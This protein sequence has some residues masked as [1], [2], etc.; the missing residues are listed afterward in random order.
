MRL[1]RG[2]ENFKKLVREITATD[3]V[4]R[5]RAVRIAA[6]ARAYISWCYYLHFGESGI[7]TPGETITMDQIEET[8]KTFYSHR[9]ANAFE[10]GV[11]SRATNE[12]DGFRSVTVGV[13]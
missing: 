10:K 1:K 6:R 4:T 13:V 7:N 9:R 11:R 12:D 8:K 2:R 3:F 5:K